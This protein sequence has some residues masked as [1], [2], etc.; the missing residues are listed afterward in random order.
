MRMPIETISLRTL[1]RRGF[2]LIEILVIAALIALFS[3]LA[4]IS[5]QYLVDSSKRKAT[6]CDVR[7]VAHVLSNVKMDFGIYPKIGYLSFS[8]DELMAAGGSNPTASLFILPSDF[9][10]MGYY[11]YNDPSTAGADETGRRSGLQ[12]KKVFDSWKGPYLP[13]SRSRALI[14]ARGYTVRMRMPN[15]A[16]NAELL[17]W[18]A[19]PWGNPYVVYLSKLAFDSS[20]GSYGV[21]WVASTTEEASYKALVVSY[22][23][24]QIPGGY[25][26]RALVTA[27]HKTTGEHFKLYKRDGNNFVA[28]TRPEYELDNSGNALSRLGALENRFGIYG[29]AMGDAA[30]PGVI[31]TNSDDIFFQIP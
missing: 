4:V 3:G 23:P 8:R 12:A 5:I 19:D 6:I 13:S 31:D 2:T 17:D 26:D 24:N 21:S 11:D 16:A 14:G 27:V 7:T 28:L 25:A 9:D 10:T 20:S 22:G 18:P 30:F 15:A 1:R 29:P